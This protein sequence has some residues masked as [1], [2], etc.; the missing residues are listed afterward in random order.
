MIVSTKAA[1]AALLLLGTA[2]GVAV[3]ATRGG[4]TEQPAVKTMP[5][6]I[7][8]VSGAHRFTVEIAKTAVEQERG[9]MYRTDLTPNGGMIFW[10]YPADGGPP[11]AASFWMKNT[12]SPLDII[13][14]RPD[15]TIARI[16][17]NA[18]PFSETPIPS[19][20]PVGAVL[21]IMGGRAATL[22][23]AEGDR[24]TWAGGPKG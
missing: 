3:V 7:A 14:I 20:E 16:A 4:D 15:G 5:L 13:Y 24:V 11:R 10:P 19:G 6:T 22:G 2:G 1:L 9:L 17:E 21:E 23:I 18:V 12:P 8:S